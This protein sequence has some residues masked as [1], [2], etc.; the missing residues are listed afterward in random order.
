M[1]YQGNIVFS[2]GVSDL[3]KSMAWYQEVLGLELDYV[4]EEIGWCE[5]KTAVPGT[6]IG[7]SQVE[8]VKA[9]DTTPTFGV[10]DIERARTHLEAYGVR[11]AGPTQT[12]SEMVKLAT[13]YDPDGNSYMLAETLRQP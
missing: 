13:F 1:G 7:L 11:F 9:G 4:M 6:T 10:A 5:L 3:H 8:A 12:V 2:I